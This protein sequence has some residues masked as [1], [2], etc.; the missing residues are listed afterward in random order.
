MPHDRSSS[1]R[2]FWY[3]RLI[4]ETLS[5][6]RKVERR[7]AQGAATTGKNSRRRVVITGIGALTPLA[8]TMSGTW[9]GL[10]AGTS[11]ISHI[12]NW[13]PDDYPVTIAGEIKGT[14]DLPGID[15]KTVRN[16]ARYAHFGLVAAQQAVC[17][18]RLTEGTYTEARSGVIVGTAAG[19]MAEIHDMSLTLDKRGYRRV[20]PHFMTTFPHNMASYHIAQ[21]YQ[22]RGPNSTVT[23]ACATGGQAITDATALIRRGDADVMLAGGA[24][25]AVFPLFVASFVAMKALSTRNAE[26]EKA[27]RPYDVGRD[28][29]VIGE[30]AAIL[31]LEELEHALARNATIYAEIL[32]AG[33]SSDAY[34][35]IAPDPSGRGAALAMSSALQDAGI[36][37]QDI[38]YVN[39]HATSTPLGDIA[40]TR[41]IKKVL[42]DEHAQRVAISASKSMLG[43]MMG[44]AGAIEAAVTTL[45]VQQGQVHPTIN[46]DNPDPECDLDY[47]PHE[48]RS[49]DIRAALSNSFGLGGQN[50]SL[51]IGRFTGD[52]GRG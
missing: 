11:G 7:V 38:D 32:G 34:H 39:A 49:L 31:V 36:G 48:G 13:E 45:S 25:H 12:E 27:S 24:E 30:G 43:H 28:G 42:G 40:E 2:P 51:V 16:L 23:T 4:L 41:A 37:P 26:P 46:L 22:M 18:A 10:L 50:A 17:D 14:P 19:G 44:V 5:Q 21:T 8:G 6:V 52:N 35:A 1:A 47:V 9:D 3:H 15:P 20:S 29:F 33:S